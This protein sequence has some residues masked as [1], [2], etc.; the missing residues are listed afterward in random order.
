MRLLRRGLANAES[1][2]LILACVGVVSK[3]SDLS[4]KTTY[5]INLIGFALHNDK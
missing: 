2:A 3:S 4:I 1:L 5:E